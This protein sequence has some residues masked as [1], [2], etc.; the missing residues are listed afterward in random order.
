MAKK[1][2]W[3]VVDLGFKEIMRRFNSLDG[4]GTSVGVHEDAGPRGEEIGNVQLALIHEFGAA[5]IPERSF[6]RRTFDA[7]LEDYVKMFAV[8]ADDVMDGASPGA[9]VGKI[10]EKSV[11]DTVETIR[12][13]IPPPNAASTVAR[14]GSSTPLID[15]GQ[16]VQSIQSKTGRDL[17]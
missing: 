12:E 6:E 7:N 15:T 17:E 13:G 3:R 8:G 11:A 9:V 14:K 1:R 4:W 5:R 10:G 2:A 16:L